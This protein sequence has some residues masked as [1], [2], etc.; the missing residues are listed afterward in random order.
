MSPDSTLVQVRQPQSGASSKKF[1]SRVVL[2]GIALAI[3]GA[4]AT[5]ARLKEGSVVAEVHAVALPPAASAEAIT[6]SGNSVPE[7]ST[8]FTGKDSEA[9]EPVPTF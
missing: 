4:L 6:P 3:V 9:S 1:V 8:V 7:A 5:T 2:A